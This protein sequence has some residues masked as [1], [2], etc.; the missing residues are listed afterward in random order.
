[1]MLTIHLFQLQNSFSTKNL[2]KYS[3]HL[4]GLWNGQPYSRVCASWAVGESLE[5][6]VHGMASWYPRNA[7]LN[8]VRIL[9]GRK[10]IAWGSGD[11]CIALVC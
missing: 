8:N 11:K 6:S 9:S 1:M 5:P 3:S 7:A 10:R 4:E 2:F